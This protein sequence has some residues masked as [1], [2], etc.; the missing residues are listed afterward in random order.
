[1]LSDDPEKYRGRPQTSLTDED[2]VIV[3]GFDKGNSKS[4]SS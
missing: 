2:C 3:E 1:V 4:Q